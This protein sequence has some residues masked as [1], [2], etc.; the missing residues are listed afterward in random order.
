[1]KRTEAQKKLI[2]AQSLE[3][4]KFPVIPPLSRAAEQR[5]TT[6]LDECTD[7]VPPEAPYSE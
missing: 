4:T 2:R 7:I 6:Q 5:Y 3:G 1:M